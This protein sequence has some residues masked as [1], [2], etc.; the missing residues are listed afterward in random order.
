M[1]DPRPSRPQPARPRTQQVPSLCVLVLL[2]PLAVCAPAEEPLSG[3]WEGE[4]DAG[5][6]QLVIRVDFKPG[7]A[8]LAAT[9]D[10]PQQGAAAVALTNVR[11]APPQVHFE[12]PAGPGLAVFEGRLAGDS[13]EGDFTQAAARGRFRLTRGSAPKKAEVP[14]SPPP[15]EEREVT[16]T[17]GAVRLAGTLTVPPGP[18]GPHAGV[19]LI[20]GSGAQNR[21]EELFG[22]KPFRVLADHLTRHGVV[23]LR[24][25]DRGVG[26]SSGDFVHSTTADFA[27]DARAAVAFLKTCPEVDPR[28]IG[29]LGHSEGGVVAPMAAAASPDVA[30]IVLLSGTSVTGE[31]VL[32]SQGEAIGRAAGYPPERTRENQELQ[33]RI[34]ACVRSGTGWEELRAE[35]R[36]KALAQLAALT[37]AQRATIPDAEAYAKKAADGQLANAQLPWF[38][39]F[40]DYDPAE[41]LARVKCPVLAI[42]GELDTQV[43][44]GV[45][46]PP[47]EAA[48]AKAGNADVTVEVVAKANHLYQTAVTG[49][50][51]EYA[52]LAKEFA[53]GFLDMVQSWIAR[54]TG[55]AK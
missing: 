10:I 16:V 17:N 1:N 53:P 24:C 20:T 23:V 25:D 52:L 6:M 27:E 32:F 13:I 28:R 43:L 19:Y 51:Q 48:L 22:F 40:L 30:F 2:L 41:A 15:Y 38:K 12:L 9:I 3:H 31:R 36:S 33:K 14:V 55:A 46:R 49:G 50:P 21:D 34:F 7:A 54:R 4:L 42:F 5:G 18:G 45:N 26:G 47:L 11:F 39:F 29:L 44:V 37:P 35:M 8:G